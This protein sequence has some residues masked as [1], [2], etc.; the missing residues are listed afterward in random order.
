MRFLLRRGSGNCKGKLNRDRR[1][2]REG[3]DDEADLS[4]VD[5]AAGDVAA[6][7]SREASVDA[8]GLAAEAV[9]PSAAGV[10]T[11]IEGEGD[12]EV[13]RRPTSPSRACEG[14]G[15]IGRA[16]WRAA[17]QAQ[18]QKTRLAD[19][20]LEAGESP[21]DGIEWSGTGNRSRPARV[22]ASW[23]WCFEVKVRSGLVWSG[24]CRG[25][26]WDR[27][28]VELQP[29]RSRSGWASR[30]LEELGRGAGAGGLG[31]ANGGAWGGFWGVG[32]PVAPG[33]RGD[34][35]LA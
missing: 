19:A 30:V 29:D 1:L 4:G 10:V 3:V 13:D 8:P 2:G 15:G 21:G 5:E 12:D 26:R 22:D 35:V 25:R 11:V 6:T 34:L 33:T 20:A 28:D 24:V 17:G 9:I 18:F 16:L 31:G 27:P 23:P 32:S 7:G 14:S